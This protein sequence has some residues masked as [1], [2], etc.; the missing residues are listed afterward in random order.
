MIDIKEHSAG[1]QSALETITKRK[2]PDPLAVTTTLAT[3]SRLAQ[4]EQ[5]QRL[6]DANE[7]IADALEWKNQ[8]EAL[9]HLYQC[10]ET[11]TSSK[12][13]Q[14]KMRFHAQSLIEDKPND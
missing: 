7:R 10:A 6:A 11:S 9:N 12:D 2:N 14:L 8:M 4:A 3:I 13:L 1:A 5:L